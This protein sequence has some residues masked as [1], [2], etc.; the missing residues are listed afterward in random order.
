MA[1]AK[2][3]I[4]LDEVSVFGGNLRFLIPH[5][6]VQDEEGEDFYQYHAPETDSGWFRASLI[7][8]TTVEPATKRLHEIAESED[9][10]LDRESGNYIQ[11]STKD[12]VQDG[13]SIHL[14][15]WVVAN[16]IPPDR[17]V[18]AVFSY[19]VLADRINDARNKRTVRLLGNLVRRAI[20]R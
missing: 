10:K 16:A 11:V 20:F 13:D 2:A 18:K 5:E 9:Y 12:S 7:T 14:Y 1:S 15:F 6:W 4:R 19:T 3:V 17:V 8:V